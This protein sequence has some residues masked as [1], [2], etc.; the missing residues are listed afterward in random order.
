MG[1]SERYQDY[2]HL[3][4]KSSLSEQWSRNT[5]FALLLINALFFLVLMSI[6]VGYQVGEHPEESFRQAI[7]RYVVLPG[8]WTGWFQKPWT[9]FTYM[10][11]SSGEAIFS[12]FA[13]WLWLY[14]FGD[15]LRRQGGNE[16]VLPIYL[17]GGVMGAIVFLSVAKGMPATS[18]LMGS[19]VSVMALA[20]AVTFW[21]PSQRM[22]TRNGEGHG[23]PIWVLFLIWL[24]LDSMTFIG[25]DVA[26]ALAQAGGLL[27]GLIYVFLLKRGIDAGAWMNRLYHGF[28]QAL[29]PSVPAS[30][31]SIK[32]HQFY[33]TGDRPPYVRKPT[34]NESRVDQILDKI[35]QTGFESLSEEEKEI[36][37]RAS[38][39]E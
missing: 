15:A 7:V 19:G 37:R 6:R 30:R 17:Y 26:Y 32:R 10:F 8:D 21:N 23:V 38:N 13:N 25:R 16:W 5:T 2:K 28:K 34:V 33:K 20:A 14:M 4:K 29:R 3:H 12:V 11:T 39:A 24:V 18:F 27:T 31:E 1:E 22:M 36:L 35:N 9:I